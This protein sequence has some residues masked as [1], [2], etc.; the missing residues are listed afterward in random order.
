MVL[1]CLGSNSSGNCYLMEDENECLILEAGIPFKEVKKV[2]DFNTSKI[3]G[4]IVTHE[5]GDHAKYVKEYVKAGIEVY[6]SAGTAENLEAEFISV[7]PMKSGYWYQMGNF[8]VTPFSVV[9]DAAEP[10]G[11]VIRHEDIGTLLFA[12]D[13]E[14]IKLNFKKLNLNHIMIECNYSQKIIDSRVYSGATDQSLRNRVLQSHMELDT[15]KNFIEM[16]KTD[17]LDNVILLHLSDGNSNERQFKKEIQSIVE[18]KTLVT[19]A[20]KG[21]TLNLNILPF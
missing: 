7:T 11:F 21:V 4:V 12:T 20:D 5:H 15:C 16:N 10:F 2:L 6:M 13:T 17:K 19:V 14:Y 3:V 1:K 18:R 8:N 9:H